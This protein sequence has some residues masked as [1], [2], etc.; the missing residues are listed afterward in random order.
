VSTKKGVITGETKTLLHANS[1]QDT[2]IKRYEKGDTPT[3]HQQNKSK[4]LSSNKESKKQIAKQN[5]T[6][7]QILSNYL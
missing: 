2:F 3:L 4:D 1:R 5:Y 7:G 6:G